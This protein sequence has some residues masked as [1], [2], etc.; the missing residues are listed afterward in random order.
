MRLSLPG[1]CREALPEGAAAVH[2]SKRFS[3]LVI[4]T[5]LILFSLR[6]L[7]LPPQATLEAEVPSRLLSYYVVD[8]DSLARCA[9]LHEQALQKSDLLAPEIRVA[10]LR[11]AGA[12]P[13]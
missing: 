6:L 4:G 5:A 10:I 2:Q 1:R 3:G 13:R 7:S 8:T 9:L 11:L 12:G